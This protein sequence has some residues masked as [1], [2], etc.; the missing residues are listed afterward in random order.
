ME[1]N[2]KEVVEDLSE[3]DIKDFEAEEEKK[4][5]DEV[6]EQDKPTVEIPEK[7]TSATVI[8]DVEG[9]TPKERA[10][11]LELTR[12]RRGI[13]EKEQKDLIKTEPIVE[14]DSDIDEELRGMGYEDNQIAG[15]KKVVDIVASKQGY[16]KKSNSYKEMADDTLTSFIE[17]HPEYAPENDKDDLYWSRFKSI[18]GS[19]YNLNGKNSKQIKSVFERVDRDVKEELGDKELDKDKIEAQKRKISDVSHTA[20]TSSKE[21]VETKKAVSAGNKTFVSSGHPGLVFKGFDE[22]EMEDILK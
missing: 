20:S 14:D 13:R 11:R 17:E 4:D 6:V 2:I 16:V 10:L 22:D 19:D 12:V 15:L 9:E 8:K 3:E 18:L 1:N 7:E 5:G 21:T